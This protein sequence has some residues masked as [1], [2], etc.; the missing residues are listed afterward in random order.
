MCK[1]EFTKVKN[2]IKSLEKYV[3][4][5]VVV[6]TGNVTVSE[7]GF[8]KV[9][10]YPWHDDYSAPL[11]AGLRLCTS[12]WILRLDTD[13][14]IDSVNIKK[15]TQAVTFSTVDAFEVNQKK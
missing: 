6:I 14:E 1:D 8:V 5:I 9:L 4:E 11:N 10:Y 13:E 7:Q 3:Q 2:I 15:V 12:K